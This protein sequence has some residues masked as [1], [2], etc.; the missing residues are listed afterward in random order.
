MI[1]YVATNLETQG[2]VDSRLLYAS[3]LFA[4]IIYDGA[5]YWIVWSNWKLEKDF[6][7]EAQRPWYW[8]GVGWVGVCVILK[9]MIILGY[10]KKQPKANLY[11]PLNDP[12]TT[13][14]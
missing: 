4:T 14:R 10:L 9:F 1:L 7:W 6:F 11:Q 3:L 5:W 8:F 12:Q 13:A 2:K